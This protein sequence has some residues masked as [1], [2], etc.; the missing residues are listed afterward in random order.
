MST[1][2]LADIFGQPAAA[3]LATAYEATLRTLTRGRWDEIP[4]TSTRL[5]IVDA[6][7]VEGR[8]NGFVSQRLATAGLAAVEQPAAAIV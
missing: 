3:A 6:M 1:N 2:A 8:V 5:A 4:N 7:L